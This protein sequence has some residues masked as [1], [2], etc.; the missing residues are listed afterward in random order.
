MQLY[1]IQSR[2]SLDELKENKEHA[3]KEGIDLSF[4]VNK[5]E[6]AS[7]LDDEIMFINISG[8]L[9]RDSAPVDREL[10]VTDYILDLTQELRY[11]EKQDN[12]KGVVFLVKSPGGMVSGCGE[13][14]ELIENLSVPAVGY[15]DG[16]ATSAAYKLVSSSDYIVAS[17]TAT[18]GNV[19]TILAYTDYSKLLEDN[20]IERKAITNSGAEYKSTFALNSLTPEQEQFLQDSIDEAGEAFKQH[21]LKNR[22]ISEDSEVFKAGWYSGQTAVDLG[23]VDELGSLDLAVERLRE[24]IAVIDSES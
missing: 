2:E 6:N 23:L 3:T 10:G 16:Y 14:A 9:V 11:A 24:M 12:I 8:P 13:V 5:R 19:G 15:C 7:V 17:K 1:Y 20:G 18:V 22:P 21:V 4:F